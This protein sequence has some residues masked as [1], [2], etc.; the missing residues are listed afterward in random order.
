MVDVGSA[1]AHRGFAPG[2]DTLD[3]VINATELFLYREFLFAVDAKAVREAT[4]ARAKRGRK[5]T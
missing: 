2:K 1:A 3:K 4:P 5:K